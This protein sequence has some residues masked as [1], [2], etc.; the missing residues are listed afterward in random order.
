VQDVLVRRL[1][2]FYE[3]PD[4]AQSVIPGVTARMK[5]LLG[6]DD[7]REAEEL[8]DYFQNVERGRI[9]A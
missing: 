9:K 7:S 3:V 4:H 1:H 8:R 5:Q 2:L 6:W